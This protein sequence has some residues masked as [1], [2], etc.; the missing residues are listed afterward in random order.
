MDKD[1]SEHLNECL[2]ELPVWIRKS[3]VLHLSTLMDDDDIN[4]I[5]QAHKDDPK[6][7]WAMYHHGWGTNVRNFLRNSVCGDNELPSRNWD[8][9]Y[10][11]LVEIALG[12]REDSH[13]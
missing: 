11:Q 1:I 2:K 5:K 8:D 13:E 6:T 10:I 3:S 12:L 4:L 7:W 9:Y